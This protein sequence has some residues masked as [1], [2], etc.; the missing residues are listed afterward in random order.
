MARLADPVLAQRR[1]RQIVD[2]A[3]S[4]FRK[5]GFHQ[6]SMQEICAAAGISAGALYRY[7]PSKA[8]IIL[9]IAEED[10][11]VMKGL[12]DS[13]AGGG[14]VTESLMTIAN[15]VVGR[16]GENQPLTADVL[17]E[18]MRDPA[19]AKRLAAQVLEMQRRLAIAIAAGQRRGSVERGIDPETA[20]RIVMVMIDGLVLRAAVLGADNGEALTEAFRTFVD[21]LLKPSRTP[22]PRRDT[23]VG[24]SS[25]S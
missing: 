15:E 20:A 16:C 21:R 3:M 23:R 4:C 6:A 12:I 8:H 19:L 2:A 22:T 25:E 9:A 10:H 18:A 5:R 13:I 11:L 7:F 17:G 14:D 1:R 24:A